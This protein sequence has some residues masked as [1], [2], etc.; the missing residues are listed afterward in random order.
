MNILSKNTVRTIAVGV[1]ALSI[2]SLG[3]L[4]FASPK[5][6][7]DGYMQTA[8]VHGKSLAG[9]LDLC[10]V[11]RPAGPAVEKCAQKT[12]QDYYRKLQAE[13]DKFQKCSAA[14]PP[15]P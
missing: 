8:T 10:Y 6:C 15:S 9:A 7:R 2:S 14:P 4:A 12:F 1:V 5:V 11:K 13:I 3:S